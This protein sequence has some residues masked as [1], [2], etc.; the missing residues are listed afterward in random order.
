MA[1]VCYYADEE[2]Y[3]EGSVIV[4]EGQEQFCADLSGLGDP[5]WVLTA[6]TALAPR[7]P[8]AN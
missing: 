4:V 5:Q 1:G 2:E 8:N 7:V 6:W 3:S